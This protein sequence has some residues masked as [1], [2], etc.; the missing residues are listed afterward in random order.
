MRAAVDDVHHRDGQQVGVRAA[1]VAKQRQ[2]GRLGGGLGD[3]ERD[4]RGSRSRRGCSCRACRRGR[5]ARRRSGAA[6]WPRSRAARARSSRAPR[7]PPSARPCR[8]SAAPPSR[9]ST[10]SNAPVDAPLGTAARAIVP[11]SSST[12]TSTVGLP[13]ESRISRALTASMLATTSTPLRTAESDSAF[14]VNPSWRRRRRPGA[15]PGPVTR[16]WRRRWPR[17]AGRRARCAGRT[18]RSCARSSQRTDSSAVA[19]VANI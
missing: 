3:R 16:R 18:P 8:R 1:E 7:R 6:R 10:A 15:P 13:R 19:F 17:A 5:S 4:A 12:S 11:S 2:L 9:S 14:P